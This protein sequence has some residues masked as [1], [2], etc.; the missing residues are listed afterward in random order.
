MGEMRFRKN[1]RHRK[2]GVPTLQILLAED[3]APQ[4]INIF[5]RKQEMVA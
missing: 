1:H 3:Q 5:E 2:V 4:T